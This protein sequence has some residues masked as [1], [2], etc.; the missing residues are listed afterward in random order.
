MLVPRLAVAAIA[1]LMLLST[2]ACSRNDGPTLSAPD[3][4]GQAQAGRLTLIDVRTPDD[5]RKTGVAKGAL[6]INMANVGGEAGFIQQ[7]ETALGGN[8]NA[9]IGLLGLA[10]N[11]AANAQEVLREA[12][13][14]RVYN[15]KEGM[16]GGS[17]GPGWIARKLPVEA[18]PRC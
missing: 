5:W 2:P 12:G 18:C 7:V 15:I 14:T 13:F 16:L 11:R 3:A 1:A 17:A 10:G 9:P 6:R 8:R 4:Y